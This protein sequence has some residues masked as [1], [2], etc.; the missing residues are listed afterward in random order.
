MYDCL[1]PEIAA[2]MSLIN[3]DH[4]NDVPITTDSLDLQTKNNFPHH[5]HTSVRSLTDKK[6]LNLKIKFAGRS[7]RKSV[8]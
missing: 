5:P 7:E 6:F 3:F 1:S 4:S 8:T 2:V